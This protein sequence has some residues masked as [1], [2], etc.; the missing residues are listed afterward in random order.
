MKNK[1]GL[2]LFFG[3]TIKLFG[4]LTIIVICFYLLY[5]F[6]FFVFGLRLPLHRHIHWVTLWRSR[7]KSRTIYLIYIHL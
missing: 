7:V 5:L 2:A 1:L 6:P 3:R 4:G